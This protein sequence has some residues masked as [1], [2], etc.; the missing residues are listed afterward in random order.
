MR[1]QLPAE[2]SKREQQVAGL[3]RRTG[4]FYVFLRTIQPRLFDE[5][6]QAELALAYGKPRGTEPVPPA[7]LAM[8]TLLQAYGQVSDAAAV[9]TATVDLRWQLVLGC[10]GATEAPFSQGVLVS[11][12]ERMVEHDLDRKLLDRTVALAKETGLFGWQKLK[13]MLDSS[14]LLGAGRVEDTW[15]LI[16]R[17]LSTVVDCAAVALSMPRERILADA[18]L[19]LLSGRSL[20]ATLD[21]DWDDPHE[22][23]A[24]LQRL[25]GE[26]DALEA[27]VAKHAAAKANEA[28]LKE[29]L[30]ALRRVLE[31]DL[32]PDPGGGI[33][34]RHGV[35]KDRMP[36]LGDKEMRHGRKSQ[37]KRFN[38][39]KRH[40]AALAGTDLIA[41]ALV[42]PANEPEH[43][44][45]VPLL[46]DVA[47]HGHT[48]ELLIDRG[49][50]GSD[51][52]DGLRREG[53]AIRAKPW[54][55]RNAGRFTKEDF[56]I[57]LTR[58]QVTCPADKRAHFAGPGSVAHFPAD[59]CDP[60]AVRTR[61]TVA[62]PGV[63]RS[64]SIHPQEELL[65][66]LRRTRKTPEGRALLRERV[67]IE[68][69]LARVG[70]VQGPRA[71]YKG[72][73]KNTLDLRRCAAVTN[74]QTL[75]RAA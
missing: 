65:L 6:F 26:V 68:H 25:L 17:A 12:R 51:A 54:P 15:N 27:W 61:C 67:G 16:G 43:D 32:E 11:F 38:G 4:K 70:A 45:L 60:C 21:I 22:Q 14:P 57:D 63:G 36:S 44:A 50:L 40:I 69:R 24:A 71:R 73:R 56:F 58:R 37:S 3:L 46:A 7:L 34:I 20:K 31:Q 18:G 49:Y 72:A 42:L 1:W 74:L 28:P 33:R 41:G 66:E 9:E 47:A 52:I 10:I 39:Y 55:S 53:V 35:A 59:A 64:I 19:R 48:T 8:V 30:Q 29:A 75:A 2:L 5:A 62:A 23:A 13:A